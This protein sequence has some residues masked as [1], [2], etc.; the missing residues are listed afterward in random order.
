MPSPSWAAPSRPTTR[1]S[2]ASKQELIDFRHCLQFQRP[3]ARLPFITPQPADAPL[4]SVCRPALA[5]TLVHPAS[6]RGVE[7]STTTPALVLF[8]A[9]SFK[10]SF[11]TKGGARPQKYGAVAL[12]AVRT[13]RGRGAHFV[14]GA[15][16]RLHCTRSNPLLLHS[17]MYASP[18]AALTHHPD[19]VFGG[20]EPA[21]LADR[22]PVAGHGVP[23][24]GAGCF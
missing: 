1:E 2:L 22:D 21:Q 23:Q 12:E 14:H 15:Q 5:A 11:E 24:Q 7:I 16:P 20:H 8:T 3:L 9:N 6:G 18:A 13:H 19:D 10:G 17:F 4:A